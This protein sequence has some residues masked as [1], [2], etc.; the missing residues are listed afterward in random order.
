MKTYLSTETPVFGWI[1]RERPGNSRSL[2]WRGQ[3]NQKW[4]DLANSQVSVQRKRR[5]PEQSHQFLSA[6]VD[7]LPD[8]SPYT[9][10]LFCVPRNTLPSTAIGVAK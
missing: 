1:S 9:T 4:D 6:A 3:R 7:P 2:R 5:Q 8:S 10:T